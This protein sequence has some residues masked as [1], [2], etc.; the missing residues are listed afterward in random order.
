M[1]MKKKMIISIICLMAGFCFFSMKNDEIKNQ[2]FDNIEALANNEYQSE[3]YCLGVGSV[4]CYGY[5]VKMMVENYKL[6]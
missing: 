3:Y 2:T 1:H 6:K 4:D 5:K